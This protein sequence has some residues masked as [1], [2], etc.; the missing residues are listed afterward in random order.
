MLRLAQEP[1]EA[2]TEEAARLLRQFYFPEK[3]FKVLE[4][5]ESQQAKLVNELGEHMR[6]SSTAMIETLTGE[7][8]RHLSVNMFNDELDERE[9]NLDELNE[10]FFMYVFKAL[11]Y[12]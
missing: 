2:G 1:D 9:L 11:L 12:T 7:E 3:V 10:K 5:R 4:T 8:K 6:N